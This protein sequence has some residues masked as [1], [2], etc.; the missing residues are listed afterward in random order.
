MIFIVCFLNYLLISLLQLPY[1]GNK[2]TSF[3]EHID[4][5]IWIV[6]GITKEKS[7]VATSSITPGTAAV[8]EW[9]GLR[10]Y[11]AAMR[12]TS[13]GKTVRLLPLVK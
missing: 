9:N 2:L 12:K 8:L 1:S 13:H 7:S 4:D 3:P 10:D 5:S 11:G 6:F